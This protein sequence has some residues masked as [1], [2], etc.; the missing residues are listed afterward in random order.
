MKDREE[1]VNASRRSF[2]KKGAAVTVGALTTGAL[3][4]TQQAKAAKASK[5]AMMYQDKPHGNQDC[6]HCVHYVP[7]SS[8]K[9]DGTCTI[10]AGSISPHGWCVAFAPTS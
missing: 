10:V 2:F 8:P 9:A 4:K 7:G 5:S 3:L 1:A 6:A